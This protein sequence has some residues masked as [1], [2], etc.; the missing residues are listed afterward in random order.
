MAVEVGDVISGEDWRDRIPEYIFIKQLIEYILSTKLSGRQLFV[1]KDYIGVDSRAKDIESLLDIKEDDVR[2]VGI[3]GLGGIGKTTIAKVVYNRIAEHF[4]GSNRIAKHFEG[5]CFL[6]NVRENSETDKGIMQ[7]QENL[8]FSILRDKDLKV[9]S[10]AH[11]ANMIRE[12][13]QSKR[14]LLILDGVDESKQIESLFGSFDWFFL[15][16]R[17][18][19]TTRDAHLL[20][21][22]KVSTTYKVKELDKHEALELFNQHAFQGNKHEEDYFEL[23]NQ[24]IQYAKGLPLAL[25]IIG[26]HLF[27]RQKSEWESAIH[28]YREILEG[29][30]HE[31]L[32][33]SYD[34]LR[35]TEKDIFLDIACFFKGRN[36]DNVVNILDACNLYPTFGIPNLVN[37]CLIT[38]SPYGKLG[39]HDLVQQM[40][41]EIVRQDSPKILKKRSRLWHY[42]DA[43]KVLTGSKGSDKIRGITWHSPNPIT[44]QLHAKAFKKMENLKFLMVRNVLVS[45][46][47]KYLP[48]E[49]K[50]LEWHKYPFSL[51][52]NYCPQQLV[53]LEMP[54]SCNRLEELFMK[55][56]QYNN[57]KSINLEWCISIRKLPDLCAPNLERLNIKGCENL[58]E[59]HEAIGSLD[60]LKNWCLRECKKLQILPSS[61]R[62]KSLEEIDL[63][64]CV[65]LEKLPD[66]GAPNLEY[67]NMDNC[68]N[69]I[70]VH[71]AIGS[72]DKLKSW[73]L[74]ECKKLQILPSSFRLKSLEEI[75]LHGCVSLEKLPDLGAPNLEYLNMGNCQNLIEVHEAI[76]SLDKLKSWYLRECKKLQILPSSFR[77]K[78]LEAIDLHGCVSLEKLPDLGAPNLEELYMDK[79][80]N[81]IEV[82]E[83]I[84]SL[85]KL[86]Q[87]MLSDCKKLQILPSTLRLKSLELISLCSCVSLEKFPNIHPEMKCGRLYFGDDN[88][89]EWPLSLKYLISGLTQLG[90]QDN[91]QNF[92]DSLVSISGYKF[93]NLGELEVYNC[94]RHIIESHILMKPDS[95]PSLEELRIDGSN[96]VTIPESIIRFTTLRCLFMRDC[97]NLREIPRLPQSIRRVVASDCMS[98]D[99]PSS[100]RLFNQLLEIFMDLSVFDYY[101]D[102]DLVLP[103]IE[104]P[105]WFKLN[106]Q[107]VGN[108]VSFVM[109]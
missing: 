6:E 41:R 22:L 77:L 11:G 46:E 7:L 28:Q 16:S 89:R 90:L 69:L 94:D 70:E 67:L 19:M 99:L 20:A 102:Y 71:E 106:H 83:A 79:C 98:L 48:N 75:D 92:W 15:G 72:L 42:E 96:I 9:E 82:H 53:V 65:S 109:E 23:A 13:L 78:S 88:I 51:P 4:E 31:V 58:I 68:E 107:G 12:R 57:L 44:V 104:I 101:C 34:G 3:L 62:L 14:V 66:L 39:M 81:L 95:F 100:C 38:I 84:G 25:K 52:P 27:G 1:T 61:F 36:K 97:E 60:K 26:S 64:G 8:L 76:G 33:V 108:S 85:D 17:V 87:W 35:P 55:G 93:T 59:V 37:K 29:P 54:R 43:L 49:L 18:L 40:G 105:K 63:D 86:K 50:L 30:I 32:K 91:C 21:T 5:I 73:Y 56:V 24:V 2:M 74:R 103:R 80:E 10:V 45:K 47:L